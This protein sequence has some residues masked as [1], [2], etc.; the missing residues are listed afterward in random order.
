MHYFGSHKYC[1]DNIQ[2]HYNQTGVL[3]SSENVN[4]RTKRPVSFTSG[5]FKDPQ[6][7]E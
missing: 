4:L 5:L 2:L 6:K 3:E 1:D 7:N